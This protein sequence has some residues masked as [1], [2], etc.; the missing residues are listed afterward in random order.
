MSWMKRL[1][2]TFH[3]RAASARSRKRGTAPR[4]RRVTVEAL[5]DRRLLS[6]DSGLAPVDTG[7]IFWWESPVV[8]GDAIYFT[9]YDADHGQE[10]WKMDV[11]ENVSLVADINPGTASSQP[12]ELT[13]LGDKLYFAASDGTHGQELWALDSSGTGRWLRSS[14][15]GSLV[16][17]PENLTVFAG[18]SSSKPISHG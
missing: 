15:E 5:E 17:G 3:A 10:L 13:V 6:V 4:G 2:A 11:S 7:G 8:F 16:W 12:T 18:R 1:A 14:Y 9:A